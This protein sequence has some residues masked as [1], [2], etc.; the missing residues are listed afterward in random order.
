[1]AV[2]G[3]LVAVSSCGVWASHCG[4]FSCFRPRALGHTDSWAQLP[5]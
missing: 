5:L 4:G 3:L 1:M 2:L